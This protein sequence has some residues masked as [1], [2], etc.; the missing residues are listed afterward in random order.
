MFTNKLKCN[1]IPI[2]KDVLKEILVKLSNRIV[3]TCS[4]YKPL[5]SISFTLLDIRTK[6]FLDYYICFCFC[7]Y[8]R[9][10]LLTSRITRILIVQVRTFTPPNSDFIAFHRLIAFNIK[11]LSA[12]RVQQLA[13]INSMETFYK[14]KGSLTVS[15][16]T[17]YKPH[18][19]ASSN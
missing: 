1:Q 11:Y 3:E 12:F 10:K 17:C 4:W 19:V 13:Q 14:P 6:M 5:N 18:F 16:C 8:W 7:F 2:P 9:L 15:L